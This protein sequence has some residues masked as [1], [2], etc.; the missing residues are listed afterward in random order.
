MG[1]KRIGGGRFD[2]LRHVKRL[3]SP[4][5]YQRQTP[6][7]ILPYLPHVEGRVLVEL[8]CGTGFYGGVLAR[9]HRG[10][11]LGLDPS[12]ELLDAFASSMRER[13]KDN[14]CLMRTERERLPLKTSSVSLLVMANVIHELTRDGGIIPELGRVVAPGGAVFLV[15]WKKRPSRVGP[16][17]FMRV[18]R[19]RSRRILAAQGFREIP[20]PEVY[21]HHYCLLMVK[22]DDASQEVVG[23][24]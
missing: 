14:I 21:L 5:R 2:P 15:D 13:E 8:G 6:E 24:D 4:G 1:K 10:T 18:S 9:Y 7:L 20:L 3:D 22:E 11:Y 12:A 16:P 17:I 19:G 23:D